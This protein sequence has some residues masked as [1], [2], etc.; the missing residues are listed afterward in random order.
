[1]AELAKSKASGAK[2]G[3]EHQKALMAAK[4]QERR[5]LDQKAKNLHDAIAEEAD[6]DLRLA[7][8]EKAKEVKK[9]LDQVES[10]IFD[11]KKDYDEA[12][13]VGDLSTIMQFIKVFRDGAFDALPIAAQAEILRERVRRI[14]IRDGGAYVEIYGKKPEPMLRLLNGGLK[15]DGVRSTRSIV[16]TGFKVA[17]PEGF[18]PPTP[19]F[20][21]RYSI[22]LSYGLVLSFCFFDRQRIDRQL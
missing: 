6:R 19:W 2:A 18:E 13:N 5:K 14:I 11:L 3:V 15:D 20:E 22:Q 21:A 1:M 7:L 8:S 16:R 9:L 12:N 4:E 17:R 10:A